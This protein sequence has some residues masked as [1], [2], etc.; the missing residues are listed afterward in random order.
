V[1]L[2]VFLAGCTVGPNYAPQQTAMPEHWIP[3]TTAPTTRQSVATTQPADVAQWWTVFNDPVLQQ[4]IER[5]IES[6]LDLKQAAARIR[7]ARASRGVARA[8]QLPNV[9]FSGAY[10]RTSVAD[11]STD[12]FRAGLD[13]TW[14]MDIFGG[15]R[16]NVEAADADIDFAVEDYR[17]VM[18]TLTAE[19]ALNYIDLRGFQ[20][21]ITIANQNL[22]SQRRSAEL[23]RRLRRAGF[24]GGLDTANA[25]AAVYSTESAIP[26]LEQNARQAMYNL[27]VLLGK[28]PAWLLDE[29]TVEKEIPATPPRVPIGLPSELLL[30][31]PDIRRAEAAIH[32]ATAR[33]GVAT[34]DLFPR[35]TLTGAISTQGT[36]FSSLFNW[37]NSLWSI[38]PNVSWPIYDAGRI[39]SNI[40]LQTAIQEELLFG[41]RR[42]VLVA[43]Q[44]VENALIAYEKEQQRYDALTSAVDANR[45]AVQFSTDLYT[46]GQIDFLNVLNAQRSLLLTEDAL[47]Q[48]ERTMTT[49]LIA[50]Y[51]ALGGGWDPNQPPPEN[52]ESAD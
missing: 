28:E 26:L 2:G 18:V 22:D 6:N 7:Q 24:V 9:D 43:L 29:L 31:R 39:Q 14:E 42:T 44:D 41:Y 8:D 11:H 12:L 47:V 50:L 45:R 3:P 1:V 40:A 5:A 34:A 52:T 32:A 15:I 33:I 49:N 20:R 51:K 27:G 25:E 23:T 38:G 36:K 35:F 17:D 48:S 19:V 13:A 4:L 10:Q 21:E 46:Q 30:R 16:R 37:N